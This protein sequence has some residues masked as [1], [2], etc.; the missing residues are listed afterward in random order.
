MTA[1]ALTNAR[2]LDVDAGHL[3]EG[4]TVFTRNGRIAEVSDRPP[5]PDDGDLIDCAGRTLMPGLIDAHVHVMISEVDIGRLK[6]MPVTLAAVRA[7]PILGGMLDRG[8][9]TVRD[10]GGGDYGLK[11]AIVSGTVRGPRMYIAGKAISQT[12]GHVDYRGPAE[13][14]PS[15][16]GCCSGLDLISHIADGKAAMLLA[17]REQLRRGA[18]HIKLTVSGGIT[19]PSDPFDSLQ[20]TAEEIKAAVEAATDWGVY[21]CAHAYSARAIRRALECGVRSIEHGNMIDAPIADLAAQRDAFVVPTLATYDGFNR[22]GAGLGMPESARVKNAGVLEAG[23]KSLEI[24]RDAGVRIGFGTDLLGSLHDRQGHEFAIRGAVLSAAEVLR[25]ATII[26]ACLI[27]READL[28]QVT[29]GMIA[30]MILVDGNPLADLTL[31]EDQGHIPL[32]IQEGRIVKDIR[33]PG[34]AG[35]ESRR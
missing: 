28:G 30:D 20:F 26:N 29:P 5:N 19:S 13:H 1:L 22:F 35:K 23:L 10:T 14:G 31:F 24:C 4:N 34:V 25:S 6:A 33:S 9:T 3:I 21:V 7:V 32:V 15:T 12:G 18:D 11:E 8:F 2:I 27:G 16:C 17:V